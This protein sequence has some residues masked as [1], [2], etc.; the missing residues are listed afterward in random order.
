[1]NLVYDAGALIALIEGEPGAEGVQALISDPSNSGIIHTI[2]MCEVFYDASRRHG[3]EAAQASYEGFLSLGLSVHD[4][5]D[6]ELW[7]AAAR[8]KAD[9][10]R[11]SLADC[12]CVAL[13]NQIDGEVVTTDHREM[14]PLAADGVCKVIFIR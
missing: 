5:L 8:I 10:R 3:E 4:V 12:I 11:V 9:Y 6:E 1:M 13:A 7:Q 2:N 14:D